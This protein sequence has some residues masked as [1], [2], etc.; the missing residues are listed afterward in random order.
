M[1]RQIFRQ[2]ALDRLASPEQL[3]RPMMTAKK[4]DEM[5]KIPKAEELKDAD[6]EKAS[7]GK[8]STS[9]FVEL[10]KGYGVK[11][12]TKPLESETDDE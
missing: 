8:S 3:D 2:A 10:E 12:P 9:R 1:S 5:A 7:G 6:L 4:S 11:V